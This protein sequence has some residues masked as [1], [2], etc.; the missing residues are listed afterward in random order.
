MG[1]LFRPRP[2]PSFKS[3][4]DAGY[5]HEPYSVSC[6]MISIEETFNLQADEIWHHIPDDPRLFMW[7]STSPKSLS[8]T[9]VKEI[10]CSG[11]LNTCSGNYRA[12]QVL[13][14]LPKGEF[15][16]SAPGS[17]DLHIMRE[18][19]WCL[20]SAQQRTFLLEKVICWIPLVPR[21]LPTPSQQLMQQNDTVKFTDA[22]RVP[23]ISSLQSYYEFHAQARQTSCT[24]R[25]FASTEL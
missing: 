9:V 4:S 25:F 5:P 22:K 10:L 2:W 14:E 23:V 6:E 24:R 18:S 11:T 15:K 16:F 13:F 12:V 1:L 21:S 19:W 3:D 7:P 17:S 8:K 20:Q